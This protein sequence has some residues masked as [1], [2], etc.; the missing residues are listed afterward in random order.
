MQDPR[1]R[2]NDEAVADFVRRS[3]EFAGG[4]NEVRQIQQVLL[5]FGVGDHFCRR[6]FMLKGKH[7]FFAEGFVNDAS[8]A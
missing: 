6:M 3:S 8:A 2:Q 4:A 5:A 1:F 7:G